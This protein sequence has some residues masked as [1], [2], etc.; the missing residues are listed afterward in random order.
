MWSITQAKF[1]GPMSAPAR[2]IAPAPWLSQKPRLPS[3]A[4]SRH[5]RLIRENCNCRMGSETLNLNRLRRYLR[6]VERTDTTARVKRK[7]FTA[8]LQTE[9]LPW[10][11]P[12]H[13]PGTAP[14]TL[15]RGKAHGDRHKG[16][17]QEGSRS[18]R[19]REL[20]KS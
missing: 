7:T 8:S 4:A 5:T 17:R 18:R 2:R 1:A 11:G 20:M 16:S 10:L 15:P 12:Q 14:I 13:V 6:W 3:H 9:A 19:R